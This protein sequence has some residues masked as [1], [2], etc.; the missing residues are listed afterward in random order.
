MQSL[1][2]AGND[3]AFILNGANS[4]DFALTAVSVIMNYKPYTLE[5]LA[6]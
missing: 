3:K 1:D 4:V 2:N 6:D 5:D